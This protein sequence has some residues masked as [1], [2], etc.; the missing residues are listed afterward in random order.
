MKITIVSLVTLAIGIAIGVFSSWSEFYGEQVP[1]KAILAA[2]AERG[3]EV[4]SDGPKVVVDG[5]EVFNFGTMDRGSKGEHDFVF[6][7]AGNKPL[8]ITMGETTCKCTAAAS[9]G[10]PMVKGDKQTIAPGQTFT[11]TLDWVIKLS[12]PD[13]SQSAE[14]K[15]NDP[16]REVVRLLIHGRTV[17]AVEF[18]SPSLEIPGV[19][20]NEPAAGEIAIYSHRK[21]KLEIVKHTWEDSETKDYFGVTFVPLSEE[22]AISK[23]ATGGMTMRVHVKPGL[24]LGITR[25][26]LSLKFNYVGIEP[27]VIPIEVRIVG[28]ISLLGPKV[29]AGGTVVLLG[30]VDSNVGLTHTVYLHIKGPHREMTNFEIERL[31]PTGSLTAKLEAPV[32]LS[33]TVKRVPI[34][35]EIP[36]GAPTGNYAKSDGSPT[37]LI[38]LKTTHPTIKQMVIPVLFVVR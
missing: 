30:S 16:R 12:E 19:T 1:S 2:I 32:T 4:P 26:S 23:W 28:D 17:E 38:V 31:E 35:I 14:F 10:K 8:V 11:M 27:Q 15:T 13:F 25:Q 22:E 24:P 34:R 37:G 5:G 3:S 20:L 6:R 36:A 33:P 29:P 9:G 7:N 18:S 21:E